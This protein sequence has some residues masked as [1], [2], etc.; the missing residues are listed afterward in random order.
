V[1]NYHILVQSEGAWNWVPLK[2][3]FRFL[4]RH[5]QHVNARGNWIT[6]K[7][8]G[9]ACLYP[10]I[11]SVSFHSGLAIL[12]S[13]NHKN[14]RSLFSF[15]FT[16]IW[17][18]FICLYFSTFKIKKG[19][20]FFSF[21]TVLYQKDSAINSRVLLLTHTQRSHTHDGY[22]FGR[23]S[24]R[25]WNKLIYVLSVPTTIRGRTEAVQLQ[26]QFYYMGVKYKK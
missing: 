16:S 17:T 12:L 11:V 7:S 21:D 19:S 24:T 22:V 2:L 4:D 10:E 23:S 1:Q 25:S 9:R 20:S 15:V 14:Y 6:I 13:R 26:L 8:Q 3:L 5:S 18:L